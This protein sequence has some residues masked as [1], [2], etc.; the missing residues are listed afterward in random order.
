M[1]QRYKKGAKAAWVGIIGNLALFGVKLFIGL[2]SNSFAV[3][4]DSIH[5]LADIATSIVVLVG[6]KYSGKSSDSEHPFGHGRIEY[7]TT[8]LLSIL[9]IVSGIEL[10]IHS[11]KISTQNKAPQVNLWI[12]GI[13][14][15][16]IIAKEVM[17]RYV[18]H[19]G[20]EISSQTLEADAWHHRTDALSSGLVIVSLTFSFFNIPLAD[21]ITGILISLFI[22][23]MGLKYAKSA[24]DSIIGEAPPKELIDKIKSIVNSYQQVLGTHNIIVHSYGVKKVV[25]LHIEIPQTLSL[26]ESHKLSERVGDRISEDCKCHAVVHV[27]PINL[28]DHTVTRVQNYLSE[29]LTN[30]P[31]ITSFH[32]IRIKKENG[33]L[34]LYFSIE[35][36]KKADKKEQHTLNNRLKKKIKDNFTQFDNIYITIEPKF[37]F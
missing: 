5:T 3:I 6:F 33:E 28:E 12:I 15:A 22:I 36:K 4:S 26:E 1:S 13:I 24:V 20:E 35:C 34:S 17:G 31:S 16:T 25:S 23:Y 2:I 9:I 14:V 37:A 11:A 30:I 8:F 27:D 21:L 10:C 29:L 19:I 18:G 7:V 32:D